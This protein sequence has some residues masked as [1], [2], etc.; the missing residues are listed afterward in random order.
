MK[1]V[2]SSRQDKMF[3]GKER[4]LILEVGNYNTKMIEVVPEARKINIE[5]GFIFATPSGTIDDDV[6]VNYE[7]LVNELMVRMKEE[8][9]TSRQL[10]V[11]LSS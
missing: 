10:T 6:I 3:K 5:K 1:K 7:E 11:S 8:K 2:K 4:H 9:I